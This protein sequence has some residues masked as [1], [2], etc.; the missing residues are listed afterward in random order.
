MRMVYIFDGTENGFY[1]AFLSA[2]H[3]DYALLSSKQ[4]QLPLGYEPKFIKTD[5]KKADKAKVRIAQIDKRALSEI[6]LLLRCGEEASE[7]V[8]FLYLR[9]I[10]KSQKPTRG[11]LQDQD[12]FDAMERIKRVSYEIHR[13]HGFIRFMETA[14]GSLYAPFSPD[15]DICDLL[16]PHFRERLP[17]FVFVLHDV[18]RKKAAVYDGEHTFVAPLEE[19]N[20]L[21]SANEQDW[22]S[23]WKKYYQAVN[24]PS[25]ERLK[26]M[27]GYMPA[28]YWKF[29]PEKE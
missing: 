9:T 19:A 25:R 26:Q 23:L 7:Q 2:Y 8:A 11:R 10:T 29:M 20:V 4:I 15:H 22:Q 28:R 24:I 16:M 5:E 21:L 18:K 27:R 17:K 13:F 3:D 6:R 1:T 14:S 12:V